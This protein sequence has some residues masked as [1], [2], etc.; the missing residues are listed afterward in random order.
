VSTIHPTLV[1]PIAATKRLLLSPSD[2]NPS[3]EDWEIVSVFNPGVALVGDRVVLLVRVAERP[4][5]MRRGLVA[6]PRFDREQGMV[7]DWMH[8]EHIEPVDPRVVRILSSGLIRLTFVSHLRVIGLGAGMEPEADE[9]IRM[10]PIYEYEEYGVE[11]PRITKIDD[12]YWITYVAVSRH[13]AATALASTTDFRTFERHGIIFPVENKDV[14]LFP[15]KIGGKYVAIHRPNGATRFTIPEMWLARSSDLM[16]WGEHA[17]LHV[18]LADWESGRIGGGVPPFRVEGGWLELYHGNRRP[19][20]PGEVGAYQAS[21]VLLDLEDPSRV[22]ARTSE[23]IMSPTEPW[24]RHGF[25]PDVVFPTGLVQR[26][27]Q[28]LIYYGAGDA[29]TAVVEMNQA[30]VLDRLR[31]VA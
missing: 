1:P 31:P 7:V 30:E 24:E 26:G 11:D 23:P 13:G 12:R 20:M 25:V 29:H 18:P 4:R 2:L 14:L 27:D 6:L 21:A 3:R 17:P 5:E 28:W 22:I 19:M 9:G 16:H 10:D 8:A 15:E